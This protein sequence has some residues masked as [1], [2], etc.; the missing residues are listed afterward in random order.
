MTSALI[1]QRKSPRS[2]RGPLIAGVCAAIAWAFVVAAPLVHACP[3]CSGNLPTLTLLQ[4]LINSDR[5][6]IARSLGGRDFEVIEP[7]KPL[8]ALPAVG[9]RAAAA[10]KPGSKLRDLRFIPG[11]DIPRA[12]GG[13]YLLLLQALGGGWMN[14]GPVPAGA[15]N[16]VRR[17]VGAKRSSDMTLADWRSRVVMLAPMLEHPVPVLATTTYAEIARAP[18]D[19]MRSTRGHVRP[20][21]LRVWLADPG[22][23][24][25]RP[26]YWLLYGINAGPGEAREIAGRVDRLAAKGGLEDLA[27]LLAADLEAGGAARRAVLRR[28]YLEQSTR[29][30]PELQEAILAFTVHADAGDAALRR[31][32]AETFGRLVRKHR[33]LGGLVA[34]DLARWQYWD[35][36]PDYI[37]LLRSRVLNPA[38]RQPVL[39]YL[40]ASGRPDALAAVAEIASSKNRPMAANPVAESPASV[41]LSGRRS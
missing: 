29:S 37:A 39:D 41:N 27:S 20:S 2:D 8:P 15:A 18:Y 1:D 31:E 28:T 19:A 30:I 40:T 9:A 24:T 38:L 16:D 26:L 12:S 10:D 22:R 32:T 23:A 4:H 35:A 36:V 33:A 13:S 25:R 7:I 21:D 6:V 17:L 34:A 11:E 3:I 14:A 5:A